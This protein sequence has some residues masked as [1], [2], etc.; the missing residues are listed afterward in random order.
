MKKQIYGSLFLAMM[1]G[2]IQAQTSFFVKPMINNKID[3]S[4][5]SPRK[6]TDFVF[7]SSPFFHYNNK[8]VNTTGLNSIDL[9][10]GFGVLLSKKHLVELDFNTDATGS[11][12]EIHFQ[13]KNLDGAYYPTSRKYIN[14]KGLNRLSLQYSYLSSS[15][16]HYIIGMSLGFKP[17][18]KI[19][20]LDPTYSEIKEI[21]DNVFLSQE[22][23]GVGFNRFN[24]YLTAGIGRD[25]YFKDFYLISFDVIINKGFSLISGT[26]TEITII[27]NGAI[28]KIITLLIVKGLE[29]IF[30]YREEYNYIL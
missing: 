24:F 28:K 30:K 22:S 5:S 19:G 29:S 21:A 13:Y 27:D 2:Q 18:S 25:F 23:W 14:G 17:P 6:F 15:K 4:S 1:F 7:N 9:G 20:K 10:L 26:G 11:G 8:E 16:F 12:Y 3:F